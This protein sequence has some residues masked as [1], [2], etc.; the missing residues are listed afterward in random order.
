[1]KKGCCIEKEN[2]AYAKHQKGDCRSDSRS[3]GNMNEDT[4]RQVQEHQRKILEEQKQQL[5]QFLARTRRP[6]VVTVVDTQE[7]D[8]ADGENAHVGKIKKSFPN[9][10]IYS[11][12]QSFSHLFSRATKDSVGV[13]ECNYIAL[14]KDILEGKLDGEFEKVRSFFL[15]S[16]G[17]RRQQHKKTCSWSVELSVIDLPTGSMVPGYNTVPLWDDIPDD[18]VLYSLGI[19]SACMDDGG[20]TIVMCST[21]S[22]LNVERM[23]SKVRMVIHLRWLAGTMEPY[24]FTKKSDLVMKENAFHVLLLKRTGCNSLLHFDKG[25]AIGR[26]LQ[27]SLDSYILKHFLPSSQRSK[28]V[29]NSGNWRGRIEKS[30]AFMLMFM[31][32]LTTP[33]S[34]VLE[35]GA[36]TGPVLR[37]CIHT[38]RWCL[39]LE[40]DHNVV[41]NHLRS[42]IAS[43]FV[44]VGASSSYVPME[45]DDVETF[46]FQVP[47]D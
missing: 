15:K 26:A 47:M 29:L 7:R 43:Y 32:F 10:M 25:N 44:D 22:I 12:I 39:V 30:V 13:L 8:C 9:D 5:E 28:Q 45:D 38:G 37:A 19:A 36:G 31:E 46:D 2:E 23:T 4:L 40:N 1:M 17:E 14:G 41:D 18:H 21:S 34:T 33:N 20:W 27:Q 35:V 16:S 6:K 11:P 24:S 3:V 42:L